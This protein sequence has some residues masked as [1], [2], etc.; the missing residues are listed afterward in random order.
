[1]L[2]DRAREPEGLRRLPGKTVADLRAAGLYKLFT[3]KRF[4]VFEMPWGTYVDVS[5]ML[6]ETIID[7]PAVQ[8]HVAESLAELETA[9]FLTD[10]LCDQLHE[11]GLSGEGVD[12][13]SKLKVY[14]DLVTA[15]KLAHS[16]AHRL[17]RMMGPVRRP[18]TTVF[19]VSIVTSVPY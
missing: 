9:D 11:W 16:S 15:G 4:G 7:Q 8:V 2:R 6:G 3:T 1:V 19:S 10:T 13:P 12:G 18:V 14:R 17:S 5:R